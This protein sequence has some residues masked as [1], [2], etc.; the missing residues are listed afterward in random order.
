[1]SWEGSISKRT[2]NLPVYCTHCKGKEQNYWSMGVLMPKSKTALLCTKQG[3]GEESVMKIN[4]IKKYIEDPLFFG[5]WQL[6][7]EVFWE[8]FAFKIGL[9]CKRSSSSEACAGRQTRMNQ[10]CPGGYR[11]RCKYE[12]LWELQRVFKCRLKNGKHTESTHRKKEKHKDNLNISR[13]IGYVLQQLHQTHSLI[14]L[15]FLLI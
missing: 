7:I 1:M 2:F 4:A 14:S 3:Q 11:E 12:Y 8:L 10:C 6:Q 13:N 15:L 5:C 9:Q